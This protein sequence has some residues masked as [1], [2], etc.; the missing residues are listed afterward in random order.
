MKIYDQQGQAAP[1]HYDNMSESGFIRKEI[2]YAITAPEPLVFC[3]GGSIF[4]RG[5]F[6]FAQEG[7]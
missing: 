2:N 3:R 7:Y 1:I 4:C 5:G 6:G